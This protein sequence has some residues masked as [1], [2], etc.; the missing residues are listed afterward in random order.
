MT[1]HK[2]GGGQARHKTGGQARRLGAFALAVFAAAALVSGCARAPKAPLAPPP[3]IT[4]SNITVFRSHTVHRGETLYRI[5]KDHG[6]GLQDL[7]SLNNISDPSQLEVGRRLLIPGVYPVVE[8]LAPSA[9]RAVTLE[10]ARQVIRVSTP[11]VWRTITVHHSAT[12][13]GGAKAFDRDHRR[14]RMGGLFYHFVL[15]NGTQSGDGEVEIGW[16]WRQQ[17]RSNR[18]YD[19]NVC[20]VGDF[21]R[22]QV[23]EAQFES[24]VNLI[25]ALQGAYLVPLDHVRKHE[26]IQGKHTACPGRYFPFDRLVQRLADKR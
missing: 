1:R 22:Q 12:R 23:S 14:R 8:T 15:G 6:V 24:L 21:S 19:V 25:A 5:A 7:M 18:P 2:I 9:G 3:C 11:G 4:P 17:V 10:E 26:D 20:L 13:R 16:R